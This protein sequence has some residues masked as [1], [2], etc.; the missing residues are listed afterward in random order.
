MHSLGHCDVNS[1]EGTRRCHS[2]VRDRHELH[3]VVA[4]QETHYKHSLCVC[5]CV[6]VTS[7]STAAR[8]L[9]LTQ[10]SDKFSY[11]ILFIEMIQVLLEDDS[12]IHPSPVISRTQ[13]L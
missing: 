1:V 5:V 7:L 11:W 13:S 3:R 8:G 12:P 6:C 2:T 10:Y 4:L 9:R